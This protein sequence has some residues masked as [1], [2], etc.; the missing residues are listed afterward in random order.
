MSKY[1]WSDTHFGHKNILT[2]EDT[3]RKFK[4][5]EEMNEELIRRWNL[6]VRGND[7]IYLLGDFSFEK[8]PTAT[9]LRLNG[10]KHLVVGNHD[11][12]RKVVM[13]L[14][15]SSIQDILT[16]RDNNVKIVCCHYPI[17]SWSGMHRG[18]LHAHGHSHGHLKRKVAHRFDVGVDEF[19]FPVEFEELVVMSLDQK[20]EPQDSHD[21]HNPTIIK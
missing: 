19:D 11:E 17:E 15:W 7:D 21:E 5:V 20:F 6:I 13:D 14:S 18:S 4:D 10:R 3:K 12:R 9:F 16:V 2:Y 1:F 8:D